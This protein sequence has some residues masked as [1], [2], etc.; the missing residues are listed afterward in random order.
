MTASVSVIRETSSVNPR[1]TLAAALLSFALITLDTFMVNVALPHIRDDLDSGAG[2]MLWV[3]N[4]YTIM[5]AALMLPAGVLA[6]RLG[7]SRAFKYGLT[8]FLGAAFVCTLAP[9][10]G[11]LIA[12]R[13]LLG[14][15]AAMM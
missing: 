4:G 13:F 2:G 7:A 9:N 11:V 15:S 12:G 5:F 14:S 6:D 3:I 1:A 10:I 8:G